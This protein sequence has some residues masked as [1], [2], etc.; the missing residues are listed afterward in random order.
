MLRPGAWAAGLD[1][2]DC[3]MRRLLSPASR[4]SLGVRRHVSGRLGAFLFV[5]LGVGPIRRVELPMR[6]GVAAH[7]AGKLSV[8]TDY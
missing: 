3:F 7:G 4:R 1:F 2:Q 8:M 6:H 5:P